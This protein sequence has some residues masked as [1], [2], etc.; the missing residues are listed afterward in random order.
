MG[1]LEWLSRCSNV[2]RHVIGR[3]ARDLINNDCADLE[4]L[5]EGK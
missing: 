5:P 4:K 1:L 2:E 3:Y